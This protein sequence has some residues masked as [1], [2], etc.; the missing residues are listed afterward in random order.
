[1]NIHD[2]RRSVLILVCDLIID[3]LL[4]HRHFEMSVSELKEVETEQLR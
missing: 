1:M 4:G 2:L 3:L